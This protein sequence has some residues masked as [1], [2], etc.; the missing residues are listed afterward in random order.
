VSPWLT[1]IIFAVSCLMT[2]RTL[3]HHKPQTSFNRMQQCII[4]YPDLTTKKHTRKC[5]CYEQSGV[6]EIL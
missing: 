6:I 2:R 5:S 3:S 4:C 1:E